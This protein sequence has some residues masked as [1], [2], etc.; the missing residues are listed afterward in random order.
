M[1]V[2]CILYRLLLTAT[3]AQHTHTHT[4]IYKLTINF[5]IVSTPKCFDAFVSSP[6][7]LIV[8]FL[9]NKSP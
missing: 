3:N 8:Y 5:Y 1:F 6:G 7:S 9:E 2:P 4:Y